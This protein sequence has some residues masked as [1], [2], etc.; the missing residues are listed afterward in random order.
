MS[1]NSRASNALKPCNPLWEVGQPSSRPTELEKA[2]LEAEW[3]RA[4][5]AAASERA[6]RIHAQMLQ[7]KRD[8]KVRL[9]I[10]AIIVISAALI[11]MGWQA[12]HEPTPT[13]SVTPPFQVAGGGT[14]LSL[15]P[16][17]AESSAADEQSAA[18]AA[19]ERLRDAFH[20]LPEEA[21]IDIVREINAK[22]LNGEMTCF[23]AWRDG[24]PALYVGNKEDKP[25]VADALNRCAAGVERLRAERNGEA[26]RK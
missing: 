20:T 25:P 15:P 8:A 17:T 26:V 22:S 9:R 10:T 1:S 3:A 7:T 6:E 24:V 21:Q 16:G 19:L 13:A 18:N 4:D 14:M 2:R 12:A 11:K 23:L 5:A